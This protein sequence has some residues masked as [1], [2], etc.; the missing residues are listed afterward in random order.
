[1]IW[2]DTGVYHNRYHNSCLPAQ[3]LAC[4]LLILKTRRDVRVVEGARLESVCRGNSTEGSNPSLS[5]NPIVE[6]PRDFQGS[7]ARR[8]LSVKPAISP[9][10][11][12]RSLDLTSGLGPE[13]RFRVTFRTVNKSNHGSLRRICPMFLNGI[14]FVVVDRVFLYQL[15]QSEPPEALAG[16]RRNSRALTSSFPPIRPPG[17]RRCREKE[18]HRESDRCDDAHAHKVSHDESGGRSAP[19]RGAPIAKRRMP[20]GLPTSRA[21][22]T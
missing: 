1:V 4:K 19:K 2:G 14:A 20:T 17:K 10:F 9:V 21:A 16:P 12:G 6:I 13:R 22:G 5:A 3:P 18:R 11:S 8:I 15:A 7:P